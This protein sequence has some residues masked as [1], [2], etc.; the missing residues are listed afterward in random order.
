VIND[1]IPG[2]SDSQTCNYLYD[3]LQRLS[4]SNCGSLWSQTFTYDSFG[5]IT[6]NGNSSFIPGYSPTTNQFTSIPGVTV[7]YDA[8]GNLLTDNLNSYTWD[9]YGDMATVNNGSAI[10]T[11]TYDAMGRMVENNAGGTYTQIVYGPNGKKLATANGQT[12]VKAFIALPGGAK[13]IYKSTGLAYYRHSDW[14][15]SSRL[16]STASQPTSMYFSSAYAP[17]GEQ[18]ATAGT[19]DASFTGQDQDTV[20]SLYDFPARRQSPSQGRWISPDPAGRAAVNLSNPQTWNRYAYVNNNPLRVID[21]TGLCGEVVA[22]QHGSAHAN[23]G[24][25]CD[26][27]TSGGDDSSGDDSSGDDNSGPGDSGASPPDN[28]VCANGPTQVGVGSTDGLTAGQLSQVEGN[29]SAYFQQQTGITVTFGSAG[30]GT[31]LDFVNNQDLPSGMS[32]SLPGQ[33][34]YNANGTYPATSYVNTQFIGSLWTDWTQSGLYSPSDGG[35]LLQGIAE[36]TEH[37]LTH[38]LTMTD[39]GGFGIP[40]IGDNGTGITQPFQVPF[41]FS[42]TPDMTTDQVIQFQN[43]TCDF[44]QGDFGGNQG[45]GDPGSPDQPAIA[46]PGRHHF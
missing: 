33:T 14:L 20:S 23:E 27:P 18:Y 43:A 13:A 2:T 30:G 7:R 16:T 11:A 40:G 25:P 19:A 41:S 38:G 42:F 17:F 37:E 28:G 5:N 36:T 21:S 1:Q 22:A 15:G 35:S 6:K 4:S 45:P 9:A 39:G 46:R 29:V 3:D 8:N 26:P 31:T 12:L 34:P 32:P 10:V 24:E 44:Q